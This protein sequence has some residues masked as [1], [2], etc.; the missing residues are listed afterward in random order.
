MDPLF[1]VST[2]PS[3]PV[4]HSSNLVYTFQERYLFTTMS[5]RLAVIQIERALLRIYYEQ[6]IATLT[7]EPDQAQP[8][9]FA[10]ELSLPSD[11]YPSHHELVESLQQI[12]FEITPQAEASAAPDENV[13]LITSVPKPLRPI[14]V[15]DLITKTLGEY[16]DQVDKDNTDATLPPAEI[17]A[18]L[19]LS[20]EAL[21][22]ASEL[23]RHTLHA[24]AT[25]PSQIISDLFL[26]P[27]SQFDPLGRSIMVSLTS[28]EIDKW[29]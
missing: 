1:T 9:L 5:D 3:Q 17:L 23:V 29:F 22:Q 21:R 26:T 11:L 25:Q 20:G 2:S 27:N 7:L 13:Y 6:Q 4:A 16:L 15:A 18:Q 10:E 12:G 8:L 24:R 14:G 28:E 19:F